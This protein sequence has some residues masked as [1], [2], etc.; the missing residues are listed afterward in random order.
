MLHSRSRGWS[1]AETKEDRIVWAGYKSRK[2]GQNPT[3]TDC[4]FGKRDGLISRQLDG[5]RGPAMGFV[6]HRGR[7]P[8]FVRVEHHPSTYILS[9]PIHIHRRRYPGLKK[10]GHGTG[11]SVLTGDLLDVSFMGERARPTW[12]GHGWGRL[13]REL[14]K[15]REWACSGCPWVCRAIF[16]MGVHLQ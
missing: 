8:A 16:Y 14:Y 1:A 9:I 4:Y 15:E 13:R 11:L 10:R 2:Q 3:T 5:M 7:H 12:P 6:T